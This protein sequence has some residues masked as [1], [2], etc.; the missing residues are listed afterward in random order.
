MTMNL[1]E[2]T[3]TPCRSGEPPLT[4]QQAE[5]LRSQSPE[6]ALLNDAHQIERT[7]RFRDFREA[8][9]FAP[10][11]RLEAQ[12]GRRSQSRPQRRRSFGIPSKTPAPGAWPGH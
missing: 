10:C 11:R 3:C 8:L 12:L 6:W 4:A 7:F 2:K 1:A 5:E 9:T